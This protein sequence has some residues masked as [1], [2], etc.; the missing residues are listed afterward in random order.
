[1]VDAKP[2]NI[3]LRGHFKLLKAQESKTENEKALMSKVPYASAMRNLMYA[4]VYMRTGIA[5]AVRVVSIYMNNLG[6]EQ[7]RAVKWI[8]RYL[9]ESSDMAL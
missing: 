6:L 7:W 3:P 8:L 2:V 5:Q 9:K 4:M 1:M